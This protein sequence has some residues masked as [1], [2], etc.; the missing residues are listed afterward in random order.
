MKTNNNN[1]NVFATAALSIFLLFSVSS[2]SDDDEN[3]QTVF[4]HEHSD[5]VTDLEKHKFEHR[6]ADQC[7][8]REIKNSANKD[9][10]AQR[11]N[12]S[13]MC[14]ARFMLKDLTAV[15]AEKF[16]EEKKSTR[17]MEIRYENAAYHCLQKKVQ[18]KSPQIF[19]YR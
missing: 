4:S 1:L 18:P 8:T 5:E 16:L 9:Y 6:F 12:Q 2:C 13:C 17:S 11:F 7:V 3:Q 15:E 10:D 19:K 14:I